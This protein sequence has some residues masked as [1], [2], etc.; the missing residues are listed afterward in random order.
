M[1]DR[2]RVNQ[3]SDARSPDRRY[4]RPM[5]SWRAGVGVYAGHGSRGD[6]ALAMLLVGAGQVEAFTLTHVAGSRAATALTSLMATAPL[7]LRRRFPVAVGTTQALSLL[8]KEAL[9]ADTYLTVPP[10][11]GVIGLYSVGAYAQRARSVTGLAAVLGLGALAVALSP[12]HA[13]GD[14]AFAALLFIAPWLAGRAR[15]RDREQTR[16]LRELTREL[17]RE[18]DAEA[19][20]AVVRERSRIAREL[21]DVIAHCVSTMVV[22]AAAAEHVMQSRPNRAREALGS[23]QSTGQEAIEEL[24]R[25]VGILRESNDSPELGPQPGVDELQTL[26]DKM[27][28]AGLPVELKIEG[29]PRPLPP[30]VDLCAYRVVQEALTNTLKH[31]DSAR[32]DV[33][34]RYTQHALKL[35]I[36]DDGQGMPRSQGAGFGL[37]GMRERVALYGGDLETGR[38]NTGG[39]AVRV[40]LPL[41]DSSR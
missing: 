29:I 39:F 33:S 31:A 1:S 14:F 41:N 25:L 4:G 5:K 26:A 24:R 40:T 12:D 2:R 6:L 22:Q 35:E 32:A 30:G 11:A 8:I 37:L 28:R 9:G 13:P 34:L 16:V 3:R 23:I 21:H 19:R 7:A 38:L 10:I 36:V 15:R 18:R 20:L 17:D 27:R